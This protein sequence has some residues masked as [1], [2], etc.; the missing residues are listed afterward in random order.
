MNVD[1]WSSLR[2]DWIKNVLRRWLRREGWHIFK[3][4]TPTE[5]PM[6]YIPNDSHKS[7]TS[8]TIK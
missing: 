1:F 6:N 8:N 2:E 4:F 3:L 7:C 5:R